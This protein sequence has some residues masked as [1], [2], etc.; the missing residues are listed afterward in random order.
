MRHVAL[1][2]GINVAGRN[3]L[4]MKQLVAA[5]ERLGWT[6]VR[7]WLQS[8]NVIFSATGETASLD[9]GL[10]QS[11]REITGLTIPVVS[12]PARRFIEILASNPFV[13]ESEAAPSRVLAYLSKAAPPSSTESLLTRAARADERVCVRDAAVWIHFPEGVGRSKLTPGVIDRAVGSPATG[14]NW[15]TLTKLRE[16]CEAE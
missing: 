4:P 9:T 11:V 14:R 1:L 12:F 10:E 6:G 2:R 15:N 13:D 3:R 8:G 16:L 7:T 5:C